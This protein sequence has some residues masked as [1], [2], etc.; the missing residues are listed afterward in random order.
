MKL[1]EY[2]LYVLIDPST[3]EIR[4]VGQ[5]SMKLHRRL[6]CHISKRE[7]TYKKD[8][9]NSLLIKNLKPIIQEVYKFYSQDEVNIAEINLINEYKNKGIRLTNL[10]AGGNVTTGYKFTEKQKEKM[11]GRKPHNLGK[12]LSA[13]Q[14]KEISNSLKEFFKENPKKGISQTSESKRKIGDKNS[15]KTALIDDLGNIIKTFESATAAAN[16]FNLRVNSVQYVCSGGRKSVFK[17]RFK[18]I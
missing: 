3:N 11:R 17:K 15:K 18:Y 8:W 5:T 7:K 2:I 13:E 14:K 10:V 12:V 9:I 6:A 16:E 1:K 4:Y